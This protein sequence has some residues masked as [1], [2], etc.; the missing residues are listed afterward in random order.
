[1]AEAASGQRSMAAIVELRSP[2]LPEPKSVPPI[3]YVPDWKAIATAK[4]C[5]GAGLLAILNLW[6]RR[7]AKKGAVF[8]W[9]R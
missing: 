2:Y 4:T 9:N 6:M 1:M 8:G 5:D 7:R 3:E